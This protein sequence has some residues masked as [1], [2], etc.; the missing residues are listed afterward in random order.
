MIKLRDYRKRAGLSQ[1][2]LA[3]LVGVKRVHIARLET[4]RTNGSVSLWLRIQ[5]ALHLS[6]KALLDAMSKKEV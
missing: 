3:E 6:S 2:E 1:C 4:G 5:D